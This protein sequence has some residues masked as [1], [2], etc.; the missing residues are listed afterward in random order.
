[1]CDKKKICHYHFVM[2]HGITF[3]LGKNPFSYTTSVTYKVSNSFLILVIDC[4]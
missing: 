3:F 2:T 4:K 1:M